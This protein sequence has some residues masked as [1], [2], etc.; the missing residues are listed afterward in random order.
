MK[1]FERERLEDF[2]TDRAREILRERQVLYYS[3]GVKLH[4][5]SL[6]V[7]GMSRKWA[8]VR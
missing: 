3:A 6:D 2:E 4:I 5:C 7:T 1:D 8:G